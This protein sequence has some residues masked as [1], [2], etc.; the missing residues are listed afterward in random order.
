MHTYSRF[1][2]RPGAGALL[3]AL[4]LGLVAGQASA[5]HSPPPTF[6]ADYR[7][8]TGPVENTSGERDVVA[9]FTVWIQG[10]S[11]VQLRF[12]E[13]Q[14]A[15]DVIGGSGSIL[16]ITSHLDGAVQEMNRYHVAEWSNRS[17]YFNGDTVQ[18]D[19]VAHPG[20]GINRVRLGRVLAEEAP[21]VIESQCGPADDRVASS[22]PRAARV[23][24][25]GCTGWLI[26]DCNECMLTA[27]H[28]GGGVG[29]IQ[30][31]VPLSNPNGSLNHPPPSD[32]YAA[33]PSSLQA[34]GGGIGNDWGYYGTFA[35]PNTGL[36]AGE[37]QG[38][39]YVLQLPP[40]I[41]ASQNIRIT[42]YGVD[43]G[44]ANQ[45]QQT[46]VGPWLEFSGSRLEYQTD[47]QGG[48]S[49]SAVL[50]EEQ[51]VAIGIHTNAG[52]SST[53][54]NTGTAINN[55]NLQ[56]ALAN[57]MG[58][59]EAS[60]QLLSAIPERL[61]SGV[62][63]SID[64]SISGLVQPGTAELNVRYD[65]GS[66]LQVPLVHGMGSF[67]Q[68]VLPP[69]TCSAQVEF[70]FSADLG[71][72]GGPVTNPANAP[73]ELYSLSVGD[74]VSTTVYD[75]EMAM[76]WAL[77]PSGDT[78][79]AGAWELVDPI[80]TAS[81]PEDDHTPGAGVQC[82]VTGQVGD[83]DDGRTSL[84]SP[85]LDLTSQ[86]NPHISYWRW[87]SNSQGI[88]INDRLRVHVSN[89][90]GGTWTSVEEVGPAPPQTNGGWFQHTFRVADFVAPTNQV[91]L[92]VRASD[93]GA[94]SAVE[95]AIDDFEVFD[96]VCT[97]M[98]A[99][100]NGNGIVDFDDIAAGRSMDM[101][102]DNIPDE[103]G[104]LGSEY[105]FCPSGPCGNDSAT[106][107]CLHSGGIGPRST[108]T[109]SL[110]VAA[111]DLVIL[112]FDLPANKPGL[113]FM[114]ASQIQVPFGDG[115]RCVGAGGIGVFRYGVQQSDASG[116][117]TMGPGLAATSLQR[118]GAAGQ[119][120]AGSTWKFQA[121]LRDPSGPCGSGF[122][123]GTALSVTFTP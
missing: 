120:T 30:F 43:G 10:A 33:D 21:T 3:V 114:G 16:R 110:S 63:A 53:N 89:D 55:G 97:A 50:W 105:C 15:G 37:A 31:N 68:A 4:T 11:S 107:G 44:S 47:T 72:C 79:T 75:M 81:Q 98:L 113:M 123:T 35:N 17:A 84:W 67:Y 2:R 87:Y 52:C 112:G 48:N 51:G 61:A 108:A 92:R 24:P 29:T 100:C 54:G 118:F 46:H 122:T 83:V 62:S 34:T 90:D 66:F 77:A 116:V 93:L 78:A 9:S 25:V 104:T 101:N 27:G 73:A 74:A 94:F 56:A 41:P 42:G 45:T 40:P 99:D 85:S 103:C 28:C 26:D 96:I 39:T 65:G 5:Q 91:R 117:F 18:V 1:P 13:V 119:I 80:G 111:D 109:G 7:H 57:P 12:D 38:M 106:T 59:C 49:G 95:A 121:W 20:T 69:P 71:Q 32:Q 6:M 64:L 8:D 115:Q 86:S 14:L 102:G 22:D 19:I 58:V 76:G 70:Y 36:T 23:L 88:N 60:I 82:W